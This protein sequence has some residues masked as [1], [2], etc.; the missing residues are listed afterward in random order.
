[1]TNAEWLDIIYAD[2]KAGEEIGQAFDAKRRDCS[3][4]GGTGRVPEWIGWTH[5][6]DRKCARCA[7]KGHILVEAGCHD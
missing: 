3:W 4:C 7:G 2:R 5:V 1:M 6:G